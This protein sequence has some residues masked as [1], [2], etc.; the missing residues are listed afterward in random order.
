MS[1]SSSASPQEVQNPM[2]E[3]MSEKSRTSDIELTKSGGGGGSGGATQ[4]PPISADAASPT[5]TP[6]PRA[7]APGPIRG[8]RRTATETPLESLFRTADTKTLDLVDLSDERDRALREK[9]T[10]IAL[11]SAETASLSM[12]A[13]LIGLFRLLYTYSFFQAF[14]FGFAISVSIVLNSSFVSARS[15]YHH[16]DIPSSVLW[17]MLTPIVNIVFAWLLDEALDVMMDTIKHSPWVNINPLI[18]NERQK[19]VYLSTGGTRP[20]LLNFRACATAIISAAFVWPPKECKLERQ[21]IA[22]MREREEVA[23][24]E[25]RPKRKKKD[26]DEEEEVIK[27]DG[28]VLC[29]SFFM[30]AFFC[31]C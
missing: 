26:D 13:H 12:S 20:V 29:V 14:L 21:E 19:Y 18:I 24:D 5:A 15:Y 30:F 23:G 6:T 9:T 8:R 10:L 22:V 11:R 25:E 28:E 31:S 7:T 2:S 16:E 17:I 4:Q 27:K 1:S 3:P